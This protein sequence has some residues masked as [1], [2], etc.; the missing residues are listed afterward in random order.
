MKSILYK[1]EN[2]YLAENQKN[3]PIIDAELYFVIDERNTL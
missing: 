3:M 1:T 2:N